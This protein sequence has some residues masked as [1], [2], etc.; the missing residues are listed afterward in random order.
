MRTVIAVIAALATFAFLSGC[1][2]VAGGSKHY[3][4]NSR[5]VES[6]GMRDLMEANKQARLG[7]SRS[8]TLAL[9]PAELLTM[10][11]V[12]ADGAATVEVWQVYAVSRDGRTSFTR[13]LYFFD[14]KLALLSD[15]R[16]NLN[17]RPELIDSW[18]TNN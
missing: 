15:E 13:W 18:R 17:E 8:E 11:S 9:Y 2:I 3:H 1:I 10:K 6:N 4:Q 7:M 12:F 16:V 5:V 14:N